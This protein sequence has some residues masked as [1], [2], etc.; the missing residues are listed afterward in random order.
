[1]KNYAKEKIT[2]A[3][4]TT[5]ADGI[6]KYEAKVKGTRLCFDANGNFIKSEKC[7]K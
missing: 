5:E 7:K 1:V 4:K 6:V 3:E 2:E